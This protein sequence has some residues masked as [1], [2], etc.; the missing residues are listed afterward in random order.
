MKLATIVLA[1]AFA[2]SSTFALAKRFVVSRAS[3]PMSRIG[4]IVG[5]IRFFVSELR[6]SKRCNRR[7]R[8]RIDVER[9][10]HV[11]VER[12]LTLTARAIRA[13]WYRD[14]QST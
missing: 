5:Q 6:Q 11:R 10:E 14:L 13:S 12:R 1:S 7:V 3:G 2:L 9:K 4:G 8:G